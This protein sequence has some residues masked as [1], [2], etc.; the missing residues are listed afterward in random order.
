MEL[1]VNLGG[2]L[3]SFAARPDPGRMVQQHLASGMSRREVLARL[4]I[5]AEAIAGPGSVASILVLD[6][7]G[8][9]RN[10]ASPNLPSDYLMAIDRLKPDPRVGTCAAAAATGNVVTTPDFL[11]DEK[12]AELRHL[13][14][15]LGFSGAWSQPI[16]SIDGRVIGTFGTYF[17]TCRLPTHDE[18]TGVEA[19]A[20]AAA[21]VLA[22][23]D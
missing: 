10:G 19:L 21:F 12:W 3:R 2:A 4:A 20:R 8:L 1:N 5:E 15:A 16:K 6:S 17:R 13:P 7:E 23:S 18:R 14:L 22:H 9:L 11:A